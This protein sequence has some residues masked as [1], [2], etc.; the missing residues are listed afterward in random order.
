MLFTGI[1]F[2]AEPASCFVHGSCQLKNKYADKAFKAG[3]PGYRPRQR[4]GV[5]GTVVS[6]TYTLKSIGI[7][8]C[9]YFPFFGLES[10]A[11]YL[12]NFN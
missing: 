2:V 6:V 11:F 9:G 1:L 7:V 3:V 4:N 5:R 10:A 12:L 8:R